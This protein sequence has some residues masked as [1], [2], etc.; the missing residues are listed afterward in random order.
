MNRRG[1]LGTLIGGIAAASAVRTFPFRVFSFPTGIITPTIPATCIRFI[2]AYDIMQDGMIT[3]LDV[4]YGL[5][6]TLELPACTDVAASLR[7]TES[8][9]LSA[10]DLRYFALRHNERFPA[11]I[12]EPRIPSNGEAWV[13]RGWE[14]PV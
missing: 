1:F 14:L 6:R 4:L 11:D 3:R 2:K 5:G 7:A 10:D 8:G 9:Q 12:L 13:Q